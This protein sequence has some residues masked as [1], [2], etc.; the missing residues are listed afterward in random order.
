MTSVWHRSFQ[1]SSLTV[2]SD[3]AGDALVVLAAHLNA[4]QVSRADSVTL[5]GQDSSVEDLIAHLSQAFDPDSQVDPEISQGILAGNLDLGR[6]D[7]T[8]VD[9]ILINGGINPTSTDYLVA[10][11]LYQTLK[12]MLWNWKWT[13]RVSSYEQEGQNKVLEPL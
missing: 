11:F 12:C 13:N 6:L 7:V 3:A 4:F 2:A 9:R 8:L 5:D 1:M 10:G